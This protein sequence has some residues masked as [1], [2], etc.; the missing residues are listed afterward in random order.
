[1]A[2]HRTG[3]QGKGKIDIDKKDTWETHLCH[4]NKACYMLRYMCDPRKFL[5]SPKVW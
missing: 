5:V 4:I 2:S 1:M 3:V